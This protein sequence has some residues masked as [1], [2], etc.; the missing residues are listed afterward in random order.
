MIAALKKLFAPP[1][2]VDQTDALRM[3]GA[4]LLLEVATADFKLEADEREVLRERIGSAYGLAGEELN[5]LIEQAMRQHDLS[6]SLHE[7][8]DLINCHG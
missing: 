7:Q 6:V 8:I 2:E 5:Q 1:A 4:L 3:A